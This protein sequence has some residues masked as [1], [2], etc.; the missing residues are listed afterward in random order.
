MDKLS[1]IS[2]AL[3]LAAD[4]FAIASLCMP[5][6]IV[7]SVSG[8]THIGLIQTCLNIY[9]RS[10]ECFI[11]DNIQPEWM[12]TF[13]FITG[14]VTCVTVTILLLACSYWR[15][16]IMRFARWSGFLAMVLFCMQQ[17]CFPLVFIWIRLVESHTSFQAVTMLASHTYSLYLHSG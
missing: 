11:P 2:G 1:I 6:W 14:G 15:Y 5:N 4:V 7:S 9:N 10:E 16:R 13:V 12:L 3:F 17:C 8:N